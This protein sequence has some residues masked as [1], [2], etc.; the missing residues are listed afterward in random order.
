MAAKTKKEEM[1]VI[2]RLIQRGAALLDQR[3]TD[4]LNKIDRSK[5]VTGSEAGK[6]I[7]QL[8]YTK[9]QPEKAEEQK[10]GYARR[11]KAVERFVVETMLAANAPLMYAGNEQRSIADDEL[12]LSSTPDGVL[13]YDDVWYPVEIKSIDPRTN[14]SKLPK[15]EHVVQLDVAIGLISK[16]LKPKN[17]RCSSGILIY[18]DASN[19]DIVHQFEV[20]HDP[21]TMKRLSDRARRVMK[22]R[23]P[24]PLDREGVRA[25]DCKFCPFTK[26][27]GVSADEL[28]SRA[29]PA[30]AAGNS[31]FADA[32]VEM[33][34]VKEQIAK[35]EAAEADLKET[36]KQELLKRKVS[37]LTASGVSVTLSVTAGRKSLDRKA[38]EKAGIDL[39]PFE[40]VGKPS[41]RLEVKRVG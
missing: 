17:V 6:C 28:S 3:E 30:R 16:H 24:E 5:Y 36:L 31:N 33:V 18:V 11:G 29:A 34:A 13:N 37:T 21:G 22:T 27:C 41:E 38:V 39:S 23:S 7:R 4:K 32:A 26:V 25:G 12:G 35:L 2:E 20:K 9:H 40:T 14:T 19:F 10:W 8:W 1:P 15:A